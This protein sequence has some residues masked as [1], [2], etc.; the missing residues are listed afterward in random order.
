MQS[1]DT[2]NRIDKD[3]LRQGTW[4]EY[5][6]AQYY[7]VSTD[8]NCIKDNGKYYHICSNDTSGPFLH[9]NIRWK[10]QYV[11]DFK[12]GLW[13]DSYTF[14]NSRKELFY[15]EGILQSPVLYFLRGHLD[16]YAEYDEIGQVW[17]V[18]RFDD[19]GNA[20]MN[21][22]SADIDFILNF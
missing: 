21:F 9:Y 13:T 14:E 22:K 10:G 17:K 5:D 1:P 18:R 11:N 15:K 20:I 7:S 6:S 19:Y 3:G 8:M 16:T 2:L 4:I 12:Q